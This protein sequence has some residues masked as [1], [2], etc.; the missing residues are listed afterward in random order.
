MKEYTTKSV[1]CLECDRRIQ[2]QGQ[3][4]DDV[5]CCAQCENDFVIT[6]LNPPEI[7]WLYDEYDDEEEVVE[8]ARE[9]RR[10]F[11]SV[12]LDEEEEDEEWLNTNWNW[13][14]AGRGHLQKMHQNRVR[15]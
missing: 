7:D 11:N 10:S 9:S 5:L 12:E 3:Q 13:I 4:V 15:R 6:N 8:L 1:L 2:L 14:R